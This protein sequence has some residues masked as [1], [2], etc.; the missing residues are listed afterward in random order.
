[1][2]TNT[3]KPSRTLAH[4]SILG[5]QDFSDAQIISMVKEQESGISTADLCRKNAISSVSFYTSKAGDMDVSEAG[6]EHGASQ[7]R[8]CLVLLADRSSVIRAHA[9]MMPARDAMKKVVAERR[10][11]GYTSSDRRMQCAT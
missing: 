9:W 5:V 11:F 1:M 7:R 8:A 6:K 10:R 2:G 4:A 3:I